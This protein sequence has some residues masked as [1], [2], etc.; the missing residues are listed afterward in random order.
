[1]KCYQNLQ[2][3]LWV[4][5]ATW[6]PS[7]KISLGC[8][9]GEGTTAEIDL[10]QRGIRRNWLYLRGVGNQLLE[11]QEAEISY[12]RE[13]KGLH[14]DG[15]WEPF[16]QLLLVLGGRGRAVTSFLSVP[17]WWCCNLE[18]VSADCLWKKVKPSLICWQLLEV[19][20]FPRS[21]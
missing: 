12:C 4:C 9:E 3:L 20:F 19:C 6:V 11:K 10:L 7:R 1:M 18:T 5:S 17:S 8:A 2:S 15:V 13:K 21:F 16:L 14:W